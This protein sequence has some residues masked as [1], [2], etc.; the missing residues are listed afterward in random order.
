MKKVWLLEHFDSDSKKWVAVDGN[1]NYYKFC[2]LVKKKLNEADS[3]ASEAIKR[4]YTDSVWTEEIRNV[5]KE[6]HN[7][8][9]NSFRIVQSQMPDESKDW[10]D[11]SE[12]KCIVNEGVYSFLWNTKNQYKDKDNGKKNWY[13][14]VI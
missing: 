9:K 2:P 14:K 8:I 6:S 12:E 4:D 7:K 13:I 1:S 10:R 11:Y 3:R 5:F